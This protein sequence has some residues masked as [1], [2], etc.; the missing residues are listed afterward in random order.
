MAGWILYNKGLDR[1]P[2]VVRTMSAF[3]L[4]RESRRRG[5]LWEWAD[6]DD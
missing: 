3:G 1:K 2:Q 4:T 6:D 5:S